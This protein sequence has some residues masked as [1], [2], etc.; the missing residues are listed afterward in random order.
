MDDTAFAENNLS[1]QQTTWVISYAYNSTSIW[2]QS[3]AN[4][5]RRLK[6]ESLQH[7]F[8]MNVY[9][10]VNI[11]CVFSVGEISRFQVYWRNGGIILLV[12]WVILQNNF[13]GYQ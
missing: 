8:Y 10:H 7:L 2:F 1:R 12:D 6:K 5:V 11:H 13:G 4:R 3:E 9:I